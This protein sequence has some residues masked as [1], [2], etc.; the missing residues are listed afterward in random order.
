MSIDKKD[1]LFATDPNIENQHL[2]HV[3]R[4]KPRTTV[5]PSR[6]SGVYY[7][8][9]EESELLTILNG[10]YRFAYRL[11]DDMPSFYREDVCDEDWDI[12]EVPSMWQFKGYGE[13]TYPNIHYPI[14]FDPPFVKVENPVG[15]YRKRFSID[16]KPGKTILH[17]SGVDNA[18]YA[19]VNGSLVGFSKGSRLSA[20][21]DI[22]ELVKEGENLLAVKVFTY[23]D[24]TYL[25]NQDMLMANG[26][27]RDVYL[28]CTDK[29]TL[30]DYRVTTT[31]DSITVNA[32]FDVDENCEVELCLDGQ[33]AY[34]P[35]KKSVC[36]TFNLVNPKLWNA[37]EPNLYDLSITLYK[38]GR[39]LETHSKKVGIMHVRVEGNKL[40]V[41][42]KPIYVKGVNRHE[43]CA[44]N[45]RAITVK[46]IENDLRIIKE[47]NLNA[48]RLSHYTN[49]PA[50]YEYAALFGLYLMDE[51]DL[52][53]HGAW[54]AGDQ[55]FLSKDPEWLDAYSDRVM[56][57]LETNKNEPCIFIWSVGNECG[58]G[59][60]LYKCVELCNRFDS[61][62]PCLITQEREGEHSG[63]RL[64]GYY[65]MSRIADYPDDGRGP[66]IAIEY[67]HAMGNSSGTLKDYWDY[68]YTHE[69]F[70]GGF[71]WE[72]KSHGFYASDE[73]GKLYTKIGGDFDNNKYHWSNF[74]LDGYLMVD[75]TPKHTWYELGNISFPAYVCKKN[76]KINI[77]NTN[78]F[79]SLS[80]LS[81]RYELIEDYT[82]I[83]SGDLVIP[84]IL[85]HEWFE[86]IDID[87]SVDSIKPGAK[88]FVNIRFYENG[89]E[90]CLKQVELDVS[91]LNKKFTPSPFE[92]T[93]SAENKVLAIFGKSFTVKLDKGYIC[94]YEKDGNVIFDRPLSLNLYRAPI[95]NDGIS[96]FSVWALRHIQKWDESLIKYYKF[97]LADISVLEKADRITVICSGKFQAETFYRGFVCTI[98]YE[99]FADGIIHVSITAQPFGDLPAVLPRF[100]F[101]LPISNSY[102]DVVWYGRGKRES[103]S[104]SIVNAPMGL[105]EAKIA[106]TYTVFDVPQD[107]GNHENTR[108]VSVSDGKNR[109]TVSAQGNMSFSYHEFPI[110]V[111]E[112]ARH[113]NEL[114][115]DEKYNYLYID[116]KMRGLG[117]KSCGPDP[118]EQYEF[119]PHS[120]RF[121]FVIST[122]NADGALEL[123]RADFG[124]QTTALSGK[125]EY[126]V[127]KMPRE[128]VDCKIEEG[129]E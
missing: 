96:N 52:E 95:D 9:K 31:Y 46:Q 98:T 21:F 28:I 12:L 53:T 13:C 14:P 71:V 23:S 2:M 65:P 26:I 56:R 16:K 76:G 10:D 127:P 49:N 24:A 121:S 50:T 92:Y 63:I 43:T 5:I 38:N 8:N 129:D 54:T 7:R 91:A 3:N 40:L 118:E 41:N 42:E 111:L 107:S 97:N 122:E 4:L 33:K 99:I 100:G 27:F 109:F 106:D 61:T 69:H 108:F 36:H 112:K 125:H 90:V 68:N 58:T 32:Q 37:E 124:K 113:R 51:A 75:G 128:L 78:D 44:D 34:Y 57:M 20:E 93:V 62:K 64:I 102:K 73:N 66:V 72:F 15:Y 123:C 117:G 47:N 55:G 22:T 85:P 103:Y 59:E 25:E 17:F 110:S 74:C 1:L 84:E 83:K 67:A 82:V 114:V 116:Y 115:K 81:A 45:G 60:N 101:C 89:K 86:I 30:W 29:A 35:L 18:F 88:Y 77:K 6:K 11:C 105:Y 126:V 19:Y 70:I 94:Y 48:I 79:R 104:D 87:T 119:H 120:F 80:Y 39:L